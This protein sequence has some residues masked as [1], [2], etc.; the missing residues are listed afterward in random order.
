MI[1]FPMFRSVWK[2]LASCK[3]PP[4]REKMKPLGVSELNLH[5]GDILT[6]FMLQLLAGVLNISYCS[7]FNYKGSA[8]LGTLVG[9]VT[10]GNRLRLRRVT[11]MSGHIPS[12][13]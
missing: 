8:V 6:M 13:L 7:V 2:N 3:L 5:W 9:K 4:K 12:S 11:G 1:S 10:R